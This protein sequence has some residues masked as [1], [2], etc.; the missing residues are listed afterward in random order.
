MLPS[1]QISYK[2][3]EGHTA[4]IIVP[5]TQIKH[6]LG[7]ISEAVHCLSETVFGNKLKHFYFPFIL[8]IGSQ[9]FTK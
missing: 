9:E 6:R 7:F 1:F 8:A 3:S 4:V 5:N 2:A